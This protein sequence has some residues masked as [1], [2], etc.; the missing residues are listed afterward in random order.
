MTASP[1][2]TVSSSSFLLMVPDENLTTSLSRVDK[3]TRTISPVSL[4]LGILTIRTLCPSA[5]TC[6]LNSSIVYLEPIEKHIQVDFQQRKYGVFPPTQRDLDP[7]T[8]NTLQSVPSQL[9]GKNT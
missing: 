7:E 9:S 6:Q 1:F 3:L 2:S 8:D 4:N 5:P